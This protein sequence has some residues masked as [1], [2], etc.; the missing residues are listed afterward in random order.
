MSGGP[1]FV[2]RQPVRSWQWGRGGGE[3]P[4]GALASRSGPDPP[5]SISGS[6]AGQP[7]ERRLTGVISYLL[8][9]Y[10]G[11]E[12]GAHGESLCGCER[13]MCMCRRPPPPRIMRSVLHERHPGVTGVIKLIKR[14]DH[15]RGV[16]HGGQGQRPFLWHADKKRIMMRVRVSVG[17]AGVAWAR[18]LWRAR[19]GGGS[20]GG[21]D[22]GGGGG[23]GGT[24]AA[25]ARRPTRHPANT[26]FSLGFVAVCVSG[27]DGERAAEGC[28]RCYLRPSARGGSARAPSLARDFARR[29]PS[30]MMACTFCSSTEARAARA[31]AESCGLSDNERAVACG[32]KIARVGASCGHAAR[33]R[34]RNHL[35]WRR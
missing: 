31:L 13:A 20:G 24:A 32:D 15:D 26:F 14:N 6:Q 5:R 8:Q 11:S 30:C 35:S 3:S 7:G 22:G 1:H 10:T 29:V 19:R 9:L 18:V 28:G 33:P 17:K 21:N 16:R 27:D 12:C 25:A 23:S 4:D 2:T 34:L